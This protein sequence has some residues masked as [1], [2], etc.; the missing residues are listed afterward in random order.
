MLYSLLSDCQNVSL[1]CTKVYTFTDG[2]NIALM[3]YYYDVSFDRKLQYIR[4]LFKL[5]SDSEQ[6][7]TVGV[8]R[9]ILNPIHG[10]NMIE[11]VYH[12]EVTLVGKSSAQ[13]SIHVLYSF[14]FS[15]NN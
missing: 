9:E 2:W 3:H 10:M 8:L 12:D 6:C 14:V 13:I 7:A 1:Y 11:H 4:E 5:H 15:S